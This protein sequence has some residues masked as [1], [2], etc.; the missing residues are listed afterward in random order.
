MN[1]NIQKQQ[2]TTQ[3]FIQGPT[4]C[5]HRP[6]Y[7][8]KGGE[9]RN[10]LKVIL[11]RIIGHIFLHYCTAKTQ[12]WEKN[13]NFKKQQQQKMNKQTKIKTLCKQNKTYYQ[14][15]FKIETFTRF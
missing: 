12:Y 15:R 13:Q 10:R 8:G 5:I 7:K 9:T 6:F 2:Y 1:I 3:Y 4:F 14:F 11:H